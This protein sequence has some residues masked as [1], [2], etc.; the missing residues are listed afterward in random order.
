[1]KK[2]TFMERLQDVLLPIGNKLS[3]QIHFASISKGLMFA[4]P[5]T[6]IGAVSQIIANPPITQ[7]LI[8]KG[9]FIATILT[10]W[11]NFATANS[12]M[13]MVPYNMTMGFY[14]VIIAF[15]VSYQLAKSYK[16]NELTSAVIGATMFVMVAAPFQTVSVVAGEA[17]SMMQV[18]PTDFLGAPGMFVAII[19]SLLS[20]EITRFCM[21][22][23]LVVKLPNSVP[24]SLSQ[25]FTAMI[26]LLLNVFII[27]GLSVASQH[28]TGVSIPVLISQLL[29]KPLSVANSIPGMVVIM[30]FASL[31]WVMGIHG[32][33][34]LYPVI[35]PLMIEA[36]VNNGQLAAQGLPTVFAPVLL[37][38]TINAIGGTGNTLGLTI[39]SARSE[40][41]QLKAV[42]KISLIPSFFGINEPVIFGL[43]IIFNPILAIPFILSPLVISFFTVLAYSSGFMNVGHIMISALMPLGV[44]KGLGAL[45]IR[46]FIFDWLMIPVTL[47][48]YYPFFKVYEKQLVTQEKAAEAAEIEANIAIESV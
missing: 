32:T 23:N 30:L 10:P 15:A 5:L 4:L 2:K 3:N 14:A 1:M 28:F 48:L 7:E 44:A 13:L 26:P 25:S 21:V 19:V 47:V 37:Y 18:M 24:P 22:K 46:N 42:G 27:F 35:M 8:D 17:T 16:M 12:E 39:L 20:V 43:P 45:S 11:F 40:S 29:V 38:G 34:I 41:K 36:V 6:I 31:L 33:M 9:G